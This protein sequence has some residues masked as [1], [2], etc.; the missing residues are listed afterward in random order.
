MEL[1]VHRTLARF[2]PNISETHRSL[3]QDELIPLIVRVL[4]TNPRFRYYQGQ[5]HVYSVTIL[6]KSTHAEHYKFEIICSQF[7]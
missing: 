2:P 6:I 7:L 3:L 1:D 4:R 5:L